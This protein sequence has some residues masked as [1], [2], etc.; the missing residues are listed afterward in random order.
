TIHAETDMAKKANGKAGASAP[1]K[2][3]SKKEAVR[4]A[5]A[6][7]GSDAKPSAMQPWIKQQFGIDMSTNHISASKGEI[8]S[9]SKKAGKAK[10]A[11]KKLA[12]PKAAAKQVPKTPA[13]TQARQATPA[14]ISL[15]DIEAVKSLVRR[16]GADQLR[17]LVNL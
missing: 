16:V 5:L 13:G 7:L 3:M 11:A 9:K 6:E 14:G 12:A 17:A 2:G 4:R 10:P 8:Q 1:Q 15:L